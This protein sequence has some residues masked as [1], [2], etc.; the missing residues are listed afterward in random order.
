[1]PS[2]DVHPSVRHMPVRGRNGRH[3]LIFFTIG[4]PYPSNFHTKRYGNIPTDTPIMGHQMQGSMKKS[5]FSTNISLYL[6][7]G[8][9]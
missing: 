6:G 8:T 2:Q 7:N 4:Q 1:M 9:R 3:I 5:R